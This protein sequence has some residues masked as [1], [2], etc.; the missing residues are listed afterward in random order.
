[1]LGIKACNAKLMTKKKKTKKSVEKTIIK[2]IV[3]T[4]KPKPSF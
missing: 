2:P 1:M 3:K 4:V